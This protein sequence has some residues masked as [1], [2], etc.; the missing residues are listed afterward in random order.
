MILWESWSQVDKVK[1]ERRIRG[2]AL[3]PS[4]VASFWRVFDLLKPSSD[5]PHWERIVAGRIVVVF[6]TELLSVNPNFYEVSGTEPLRFG[7]HFN[8]N[9]SSC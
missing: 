1:A 6:V 2:A 8:L 5:P 3:I 9:I 4:I 7:F